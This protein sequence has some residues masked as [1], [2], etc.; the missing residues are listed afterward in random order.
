MKNHSLK[1]H[2]SFVTQSLIKFVAEAHRGV[3]GFVLNMEGDPVR[4]AS[5]RIKGRDIGVLTTDNGEFWRIL[6]PGFYKLEV[7]GCI[8]C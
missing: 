8:N 5:I 1:I 2:R 7:C 4:K 3:H 6:L